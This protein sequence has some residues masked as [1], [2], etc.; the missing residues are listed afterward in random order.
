ML[1]LN[2][3]FCTPI[4]K[5]ELNFDTLKV[6]EQ[7]FNIE[8]NRASDNKS[9]VGGYQTQISWDENEDFYN[10]KNLICET[11]DDIISTCFIN[12]KSLTLD[13]CWININR[14]GNYNSVHYHPGSF[15][16]GCL[17][18]Q[19]EDDSGDIVFERPDLAG[20][21]TAGVKEPFF[22]MDVGYKPTDGLILIFPSWV[23]HYVTASTS[24]KPRISLAF[25][26]LKSG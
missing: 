11:L 15:L 13:N 10:C 14:T 12:T 6:A 4:W 7:C 23:P 20:H 3:C 25:N 2:L 1:D 26:V 8:K 9:N 18:I 17:Y 24:N 19:T 21:Y 5:K 16:S 22:G